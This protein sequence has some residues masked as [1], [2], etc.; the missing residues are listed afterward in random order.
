MDSLGNVNETWV[1]KTARTA[2]LSEL[3][4]FTI[5]LKSGWN[6]ISIPLNLTTWILGDE[7]AVGNPLNV[8]PTNCLSSIYRYNSTSKLFEKSDHIS[9]WGWWPAA[10]PVKFIELEPGRGYW[11]MAQQDFILTFTGT[12]PSDRDVH[13]AS[14]WNLIGWYSMNEAALGEESVVGDPLNVTTRNSLTSIYQFNSTSD[15]FEKFDHIADWGWWPAPGPV[16]F[17]EMEP[18]RGYRVNAKNDA[19]FCFL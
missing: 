15:L 1:N 8:T 17:A 5:S 2:P 3:L 7:S 13:M 12:A 10:G 16:R 9:N 14:G 11:V 6:L 19:F 18:G 4:T